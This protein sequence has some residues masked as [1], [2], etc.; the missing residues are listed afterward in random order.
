[1]TKFVLC[2]LAAS[3]LVGCAQARA[4]AP[5]PGDP[6]SAKGVGEAAVAAEAPAPRTRF[7]SSTVEAMR[8]CLEFS[9]RSIVL[10]APAAGAG[11]LLPAQ[12]S[13]HDAQEFVV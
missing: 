2:L 4:T 8:D 3:T 7:R 1:M 11:S 10:G 13:C 5:T 12:T 6:A 9:D